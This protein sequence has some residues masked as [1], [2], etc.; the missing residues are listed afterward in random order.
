MH[1]TDSVISKPDFEYF[2][3]QAKAPFAI[4]T[5]KE[6]IFTFANPA[7]I[8]LLNGRQLVGKKLLEAIPELEGQPFHELLE[9][10]FTTGTPFHA[11]EIEAVAYYTGDIT[12]TKRYFNLSYTPY[13]NENGETEGILASGYDVTEQVAL[14]K[15]QEKSTLNAHVYNLFMQAPFPVTIFK[16]H[17]L[18]I[19]LVN[20]AALKVA[21]KTKDIIGKRVLE[22][23]PELEGHGFLQ[24]AR[25]VMRTGVPFHASESPMILNVDGNH[26]LF[27]MNYI[28]QPYFEE[29]DVI[30]GIMVTSHDVTEQ[31]LARKKIEKVEARARLAIESSGLGVFDVDLINN[32]VENSQRLD[33]IFDVEHSNERERYV[34]AIHP[35]DLVKRD[36][37]YKKAYTDGILQYE[38]R[39]ISKN[40]AIR[41]IRANGK[42][43]FDEKGWPGHLHGVVQDITDQKLFAEELEKQVMQRTEELNKANELLKKINSELEQFAHVSSH[44]LQEPLRKILMFTGLIR[45]ADYDKLSDTSQLRF[46]KIIDSANRM[47][48]SLKDLLNFTS[49]SKEE[50]FTLVNLN[51]VLRSVENDLELV[52]SNK[53]ATINSTDL[54]VIRAIPLQMHQ[55]FYNLTNN[56]L[57]FS[58]PEV[59][60]VVTIHHSELK[61]ERKKLYNGID[62]LL[63]Y[64]E[65]SVTDNGIGF[66]QVYAEKIFTMFQ[67][68]HHNNKFS[69]TGIGLALCKK[70]TLNHNGQI[71]AESEPGK[72]STFYIA[73]PK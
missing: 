16:G 11:S 41:W 36:I 30:T 35:D 25:K 8:S 55:L 37:A 27:Y 40:K 62:P 34:S 12:P 9:K 58:N 21:G 23:V 18:V 1:L 17:E 24:L 65:I 39:I 44:D 49:L 63:D 71:F 59:K 43:F 26:E 5:G 45:D 56:A 54:P 10:V 6:F 38:V 70:V 53:Q 13:K 33:E 50:Q 31:V 68:L 2:F 64:Y 28:M 3:N 57:K 15:S 48:K 72:G 66:N 51:E 61:D 7:Y 60:P 29:N 4:L 22:T 69:G 46:D 32:I 20:D 52:I 14:K 19:E 67:R 73:L 47:S 42:I